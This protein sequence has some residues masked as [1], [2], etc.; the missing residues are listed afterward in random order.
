MPTR[1]FL[2][3][4]DQLSNTLTALKQVCAACKT[5]S[6]PIIYQACSSVELGSEC[7]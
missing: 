2:Q 6:T 7:S 3:N 1:V 4:S 5:D